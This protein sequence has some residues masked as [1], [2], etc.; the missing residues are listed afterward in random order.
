[1]RKPKSLFWRVALSYGALILVFAGLVVLLSAVMQGRSPGPFQAGV[2]AMGLAAVAISIGLASLLVRRTSTSISSFANSA[3]RLAAGDLDSEEIRSLA[4]DSTEE[5]AAAFIRMSEAIRGTVRDLSGERNK[6][7]ALLDTMADGIVVVE[8]DGRVSLMNQAAQLLLDLRTTEIQGTPLSEIARDHELLELVSSSRQ[9]REMRQAH[10]E[11][12]RQRR[13]VSAI[14]IPLGG[15]GNGDGVLLS[16]HDLTAFRQLETTRREFVSN[17]SHELRSPL[18][19]IRSMVETL[20][21][22]AIDDR[23]TAADFV[24]RIEQDVRRMDTL[25]SELLEL[26][27]LESGQV[28]L[29]VRPISLG[30][31][32]SDTAAAFHDRSAGSGV[33]VSIEIPDDLPLVSGE[34]E[35][36]RQVLM[37]LMDNALKFTPPGGRITMSALPGERVV[38]ARVSNTGDGIAPEHLPHLFERFYKVDRSRRD[39][40]TGL[41]LAIV[42]HIVL[43]H[44]GDVDVESSLGEGATFTFTLPRA[45]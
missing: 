32:A 25:V 14:A 22:G 31:I 45:S 44:G 34:S 41:G 1:M 13:L 17:V 23:Q 16:L 19:S 15:S 24:G 43:A 20:S 35:K 33:E 26:S 37:N 3:D 40:G 36:I 8:D 28:A 10:L 2:V 18:A 38:T 4:A 12:L 11:L 30:P 5:L 21:G 6:L 29:D 39:Q 42:K 9:A 27:R 7:T